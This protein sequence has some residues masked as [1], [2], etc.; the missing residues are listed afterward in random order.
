[1]LFD[2]RAQVNWVHTAFDI[3]DDC[4]VIELKNSLEINRIFS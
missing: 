1:M 2:E 3:E 4:R